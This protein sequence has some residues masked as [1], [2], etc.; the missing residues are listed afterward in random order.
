MEL[1]MSADALA[2]LREVCR[3]LGVP[4]DRW[5]LVPAIARPFE[6]MAAMEEAERIREARGVAWKDA[7]EEA[8]VKLGLN[9]ATAATRARRR[10][11]E[12]YGRVA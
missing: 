10:F 4:L 9:P 1:A 6:Q 11:L 12:A 5:H 8:A 7:L 2:G 3:V